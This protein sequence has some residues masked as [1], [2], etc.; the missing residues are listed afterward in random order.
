MPS[1][2][3]VPRPDPDNPEGLAF[4]MSVGMIDPRAGKTIAD[5]QPMMLI[6]GWAAQSRIFWDL[7]IRYHPELATKHLK[8]GGQFMVADI[9]D[10]PPPPPEPELNEEQVAERILDIVAEQNPEFARKIRA[11]KTGSEAERAAVRESL[12]ADMQEQTDVQGNV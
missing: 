2:V 9:V 7:G 5:R 10:G 11:L 3:K 8:G 12:W 1:P 6:Q 4:L